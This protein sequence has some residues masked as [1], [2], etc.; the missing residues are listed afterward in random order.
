MNVNQWYDLYNVTRDNTLYLLAE[1][2][3]YLW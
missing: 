1:K 2:R 3:T